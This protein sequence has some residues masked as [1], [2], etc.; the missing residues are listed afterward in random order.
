MYAVYV[1]RIDQYSDNCAVHGLVGY[2]LYGN[3]AHTEGWGRGPGIFLRR[4]SEKKPSGDCE[5]TY[6]NISVAKICC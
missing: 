4:F 1:C 2:H 3:I 5:V 6:F